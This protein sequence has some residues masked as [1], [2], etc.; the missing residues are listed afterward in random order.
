MGQRAGC[1]MLNKDTLIL[2]AV[3]LLSGLLSEDII[4]RSVMCLEN[5]QSSMACLKIMIDNALSLEGVINDVCICTMVIKKDYS[6]DDQEITMGIT[7]IFFSSLIILQF[8]NKWN[9]HEKLN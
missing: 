2:E 9:G 4:L 5:L 1:V 8:K 3:T 6:Y 7:A